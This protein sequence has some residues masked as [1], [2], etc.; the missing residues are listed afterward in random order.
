MRPA[1]SGDADAVDVMSVAGESPE[2]K[3]ADG[4]TTSATDELSALYPGLMDADDRGDAQA[5]ARLGWVLFEMT[6]TAQHARREA[7]ASLD[8]LRV[9]A[10][11]AVVSRGTPASLALLHSVL[12]SHGWLPPRD[13]TPLQVLAAPGWPRF[14]AR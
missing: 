2:D 10:R 9:A 13:A 5:L 7:L 4:E 11:V 12:A 1:S 14:T 8:E 6:S 3:S